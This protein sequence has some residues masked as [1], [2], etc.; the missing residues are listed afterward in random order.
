MNTNDYSNFGNPV[1]TTFNMHC[2]AVDS[3]SAN[4]L[5]AATGVGKYHNGYDPQNSTE[6]LIFDQGLDTALLS[7]MNPI[8]PDLKET[9]YIV[10]IDSRLGSLARDDGTIANYSFL[11]DDNIA[12]YYFTEGGTTGNNSGYIALVGAPGNTADLP[13]L[14]SCIDGP[15]GTRFTFK[16]K[17]SLELESSIFLFD[18]IGLAGTTAIDGINYRILDSIIK[19]MGATT[20]YSVEIPIR[21]L[22]KVT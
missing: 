2:I 10:H 20:G 4:A 6:K 13:S 5:N 21:Y 9:Q 15:R 16:I 18:Q 11:D 22:K 1:N 3:D 14:T 8:D 12:T 19:I 7:A 17:A